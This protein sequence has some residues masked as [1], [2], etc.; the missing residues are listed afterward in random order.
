MSTNYYRIP[1][2]S[3]TIQRFQ[4]LGTE[5]Q[6]L[7]L[8]S[9]ADTL[10]LFRTIQDPDDEWTHMSPWDQFVDGLCVHLGKRSSG[11]KFLWNWNS[12]KHYKDKES[13]LKYIRSGRI[14]DEYGALQNTE[15]FIEMA[16]SWCVPNGWDIARYN[17]EN[18][19]TKPSWYEGTHEEYIDGLRVSTS[20]DFS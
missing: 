18:P 10:N 2:T 9:P 1:K 6:G 14:V 20:V 19:R 7:D 17:K 16:L 15:E 8:V 3:E 4:R 11:W 12:R 5:L 13:L